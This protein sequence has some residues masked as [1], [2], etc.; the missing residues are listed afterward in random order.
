[1]EF[2]DRL[3]IVMIGGTG[4]VGRESVAK[5]LELP[6]LERLTLLG[7]RPLEGFTSDKIVQHKVDVFD[8]NSYQHFIEGHDI[9]ICT[10]GV[11]EPSKVSKEEFIKI[12]KLAVFDFAQRC[13]GAGVSHFQLLSSVGASSSSLSHYLRV[14]GEL[15]DDLESMAFRRLS[16]FMPSMIITPSN[17]Y[18]FSQAV[19]LAVWPLLSHLFIFKMD[20]YRGVKVEELGSAIALNTVVVNRGVERLSWRDFKSINRVL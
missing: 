10:L 3:T 2:S 14:K 4:A 18:G 6:N 5:L 11:G 13:K 15:I 1:M 7:R 8:I 17:R 19:V 9:A 12:D 16:I 20:R